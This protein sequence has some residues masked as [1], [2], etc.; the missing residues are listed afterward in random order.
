ML[1][2]SCRCRNLTSF[3]I[4]ISKKKG[5]PIIR[6]LVI[7]ITQ[8]K[9]FPHKRYYST[10]VFLKVGG[11]DYNTKNHYNT[12]FLLILINFANFYNKYYNTNLIITQLKL[13]F[14]LRNYNFFLLKKKFSPGLVHLK[15][16]SDLKRLKHWNQRGLR[17]NFLTFVL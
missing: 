6:Q 3:L 15:L 11:K 14:C 9:S 10:K 13:N 12:K 2:D 16:K 4:F 1:Q 17:I 8:K 5:W 7:F